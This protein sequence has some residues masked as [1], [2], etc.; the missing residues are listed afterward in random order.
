MKKIKYLIIILITSSLTIFSCQDVLD[1]VVVSGVTGEYLNTPEGFKA[2]VNASYQRLR[3]YYGNSEH[4]HNLTVFGT[5]EFTNGGHGGFHYMNKYE[6]GLNAE[7]S[8]FWHL[9]QNFYLGINACNAVITRAADSDMTPEQKNPGLGEVRFLRAHY[10]FILVQHFGPVHLTLEETVGVETEANR[11]SEDV[12]YNAIIDDLE[13]AI[14]NLPVIQSE[15]GRITRP[16]AENMLAEVLLTRGY[17][18]FA[19]SNDFSRAAE[20]AT[21]VINNYNFVL[22]DDLTEV[23]NHDNEQNAE[24]IWSVQYSE[25]PLLWPGNNSHLY[26]RPWYEVYNDGLNRALGHGYGRPWIRV[27]P[28]PWLLEN[29]RP[30]DVDSR[31]E[32]NFQ[33]VWYYNSTNNIPAGASVGDTAIWVTDKYLTQADVDAIEARLPGVNL[34]T[35]HHDNMDDPWYRERNIFPNPWK[36]DDNKRPS[37]NEANGSRDF[38]VYKLSKTYLVAAEA[39]YMRDGN[40]TAAVEYINTLRRRA[41]HPGMESEMEITSADVDLDFILDERSRELFGEYS[42]WKDLKR[43]GKLLERVQKYNP[44]EGADN[45]RDFHV[46]RPIPA[47]QLIRTSNDY[48][49]NPG[50]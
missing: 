44:D 31:F 42:R 36:F 15:F 2:G 22:F 5:D 50:Y 39:M 45:I 13:F 41:A 34:F 43:T 35:W 47:N 10:Y 37:V 18:D 32:K 3:N 21:G 40:G 24:I 19:Q 23:W 9:W 30:L 12:I 49:Q 38:I 27:N 26:F 1:E 20:L 46:L 28:T 33:S 29:F 7:A 16:A 14:A 25:D 48:G 4:G 17:T 6:A 11:T 8:P